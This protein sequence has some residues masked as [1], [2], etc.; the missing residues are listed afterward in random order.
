M[1]QFR[2]H[3]QWAST[4][5]WTGEANRSISLWN[6]QGLCVKEGKYQIINYK[7]KNSMKV[8]KVKYTVLFNIP[9][10]VSLNRT[11]CWHCL[12]PSCFSLTLPLPL[13]LSLPF[14]F[15]FFP[16]AFSLPHLPISWRQYAYFC[17]IL[18]LVLCL[19]ALSSGHWMNVLRN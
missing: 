7:S 18:S 14:C 16:L 12:L 10:V 17:L 3:F 8:R 5:C 2:E 11:V 9:G 19:I 15:L 13:F 4:E 1:E 6:F